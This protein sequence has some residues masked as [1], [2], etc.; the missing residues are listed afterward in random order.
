MATTVDVFGRVEDDGTVSVHDAGEWRVVGS[1]PDGTAEEALAYYVRKYEELDSGVTLA[2]QRFKAGAAVRDLKKQVEKL[3]LELVSPSAVGDLAAL[4]HRV[5]ALQ[6]KLPA[7]EAEQDS[8]AQVA[9]AEALAQ[10]EKIVAE[11]EALAAQDPEKIRWKQATATMSELF[12]AWQ[13]HQQSGARV[14][15]KTADALWS[16]FRAARN[17]LERARRAYFQEL[18]KRSKDAKTTKKDLIAKA[19]ALAASGPAGISTYR[20]L[21]EQWKLAPRASK[22]IEDNL[23]AQFKKAGDALYQA[24][25]EEDRAD[26]DKNAANLDAKKALIT[27]F[28]DIL[29][30]QDK[31]QA[32]ARLRLFHTRFGSIGPVPKK[33]VRSVD[34][35]VKKFDTHVRSLEQE[36]WSKNDPEKLAR[37]ESMAGQLNATIAR[38]EAELATASGAAKQALEEELTTKKA[39]LAVIDR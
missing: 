22:S 25:A 28:A 18:D 13:G 37:S 7:L 35:E 9:L 31:A 6:E 24:K 30:L 34:D 38:L 4:R 5:G 12:E 26:D 10:R 14:P 1:F 20:G 23:W 8:S 27:E 2:E 36:F 3:T 17:Q 16:R 39:W 29:N 33:N 11:M 19:E 15:K 21:L 32:S